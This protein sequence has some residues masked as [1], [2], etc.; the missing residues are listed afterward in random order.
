MTIAGLDTRIGG[1]ALPSLP[2]HHHP[3]RSARRVVRQGGRGGRPPGP[4][5]L[6]ARSSP[7]ASPP[8]SSAIWRRDVRAVRYGA[9]PAC[10]CCQK[11]WLVAIGAAG[12]RPWRCDCPVEARDD[13]SRLHAGLL[14]ENRAAPGRPAPPSRAEGGG[15]WRSLGHLWIAT[16]PAASRALG[17]ELG[18]DGLG[19]LDRDGE[20]DQPAP[21]CE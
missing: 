16:Q 18:Q 11:P 12:R 17:L 5:I 4:A 15:P 19:H 2:S 6:G 3:V 9:P 8:A 21:L 7:P 10:Q 13:V 14:P 20:A 1:R